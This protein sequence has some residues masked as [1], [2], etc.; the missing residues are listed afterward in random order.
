[1]SCDNFEINKENVGKNEFSINSLHYEHNV[2][3]RS[4]PDNEELYINSSIL[5]YADKDKLI[6]LGKIDSS[7]IIT[8]ANL[9]ELIANFDNKLPNIIIANLIGLLI[10]STRGF[11]LLKAEG[12]PLQGAILPAIDPMTFFT[13]NETT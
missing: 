13:K 11:L 1:M 5:I 9:K 3:L 2:S 12:T 10:S 4:N 8:V 6:N 7:T